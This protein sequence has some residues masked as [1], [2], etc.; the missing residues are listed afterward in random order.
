LS[1]DL[2]LCIIRRHR[3]KDRKYDGIMKEK[4]NVQQNTTQKA[5]DLEP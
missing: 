5:K 3:L 2:R 1:F 4:N